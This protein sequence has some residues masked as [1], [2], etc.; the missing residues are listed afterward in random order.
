MDNNRYYVVLSY[1]P[2]IR[3]P[4]GPDSVTWYRYIGCGGIFVAALFLAAM[5]L[6]FGGLLCRCLQHVVVIQARS[7]IYIYILK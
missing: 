2:P 6:L 5:G 1:I 7:I 3:Y 4:F